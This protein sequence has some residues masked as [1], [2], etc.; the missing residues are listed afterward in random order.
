MKNDGKVWDWGYNNYGQLG[1]GNNTDSNVPIEVSGRSQVTTAI[2]EVPQLTDMSAFPNP[3]EKELTISGT[4]NS[5]TSTIID[6]NGKEIIRVNTLD[7]SSKVNIDHLK[8][9]FYML[10]YREAGKI[11]NIKLVKF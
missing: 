11:A 2:T 10:K 3:L 5:G 7:G 4:K 1:N 8:P 9:G 6:S